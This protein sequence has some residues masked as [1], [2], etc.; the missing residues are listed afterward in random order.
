MAS[1][2]TLRSMYRTGLVNL[3]T[4]DIQAGVHFYRD[5]LGFVE[6]FRTPAEGVPEHIEL[7]LNGFKIGLGTVSS[8]ADKLTPSNTVGPVKAPV[9]TISYATVA[10]MLKP[11]TT[12]TPATLASSAAMRAY[13]STL[14]SCGAG[15][16]ACPGIVTATNRVPA[17]ADSAITSAY[18]RALHIPPGSSSTVRS[19]AVG[20]DSTSSH[21]VSMASRL[22]RLN[23][24]SHE[25][26]IPWKGMTSR[27]VPCSLPSHFLAVM[28]HRREGAVPTHRRR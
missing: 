27:L 26:I 3:Y 7:Q 4:R 20:P 25:A 15:A 18:E 11:T 6:T 23:P 10:P 14:K 28:A 21:R 19:A 12:S 2:A 1:L 8:G 24:S 16:P 5:L 9:T 22:A 17:N 13:S